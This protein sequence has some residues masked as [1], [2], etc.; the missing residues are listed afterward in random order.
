M[1]LRT[2]SLFALVAAGAALSATA[3]AADS[4][5]KKPAEDRREV[6][7]SFRGGA[8]MSPASSYRA[9]AEAFG[10]TGLGNAGGGTI[11]AGYEIRD[12]LVLG[13]TYSHFTAKSVRRLST[14]NLATSVLLGGIDYTIAHGRW[15]NEQHMRLFV[16]ASLA[17]GMYFIDEKFDSK[18]RSVQGYGARVG[19]N[20][21]ILYH[22][23][24]L[25]IGFAYHASNATLSDLVGGKMEAAGFEVTVGVA[26][27]L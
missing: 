12:R 6:V 14:L 24:G 15:G 3:V 27:R 10:F 16:D 8:L 9:D 23:V 1:K 11:H 19:G 26:L 13:V 4:D 17:A 5:I 22:A 25:V 2:P 21:A 7:V 20:V 18:T